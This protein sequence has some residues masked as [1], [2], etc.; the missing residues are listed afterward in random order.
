MINK[1]LVNK[2]VFNKIINLIIEG[3]F[4]TNAWVFLFNH[5]L[6]FLNRKFP[7]LPATNFVIDGASPEPFEILLYLVLSFLTVIII[8]FFHKKNRYIFDYLTQFDHTLILKI[9]KFIFLSFLLV[10][11]INNLGGFPMGKDVWPLVNVESNFTYLIYLIGYVSIVSFITFESGWLNYFVHKKNFLT[12]F[13]LFLIALIAFLTLKPN[14]PFSWHDYPYIYGPV[15]EIAHGKTIFTQVQSQYGFLLVLFLVV[16]YKLYLINLSTLP[17]FIWL[18]YIAQY[19]LCFYLIYK[20]SRS[21]VLAFIGLFS[22]ITINYYSL[23]CTITFPQISALRWLSIILL[24]F[25]FYKMKRIDSYLFIL[26]LS[27]LSFWIIDVG[28]AILM[29]YSFSLLLL[30]LVKIIDF[31][32]LVRNYLLLGLALAGIFFLINL[33]GL[34]FGYRL[35]NILSVFTKI[36]EYS[37]AGFGMIPMTSKSYF[38]FTLLIYF[39]SLIYFFQRKQYALIDQILLFSANLTLFASV[40]FVGRSHPLNLFTIAIFPLLTF[41][42]LISRLYTSEI[43][44]KS[45]LLRLSIIIFLLFSFVIVPAYARKEMLTINLKE[46]LTRLANN[47]NV[48]DSGL[49]TYLNFFYGSEKVLINKYLKDDNIF[50]LSADDTYLLYLVNKGSL[51]NINPLT[52]AITISDIEFGL[53]NI[54]M[55][56]PEKIA[57]D[58]EVFNQCPVYGKLNLLQYPYNIILGQLTKKCHTNYQPIEC[59]NMLCIAKAVKIK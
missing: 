48:F 5:L 25:L 20:L 39:S 57:A 36:Q 54:Y 31:K 27:L 55:T 32:R 26:I 38:W 13:Y 44:N 21:F 29:A 59:T 47:K 43:V 11:F 53:K 30:A 51:S 37:R 56:C 23:C 40:Y 19:F 46:E 4:I 35:I 8:Y 33:I 3:L 2:T 12:I 34:I 42:I 24:I 28:I 22:I 7:S 41:F 45:F 58:C 49:D 52:A 6:N 17:I 1:I 16:L 18:L 9:L 15:F 14:F 50:I 10:I